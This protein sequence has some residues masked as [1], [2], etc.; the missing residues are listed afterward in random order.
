MGRAISSPPYLLRVGR[1]PPPVR[2]PAV[3]VLTKQPHS[4]FVVFI[5]AARIPALIQFHKGAMRRRLL[6]TAALIPALL[7]V[8]QTFLGA[9]EAPKTPATQP[10]TAPAVEVQADGSILLKA[11]G[12]RIHG[13]RLHLEAKPEPTLVY[14]ID[15]TEYPEWPQAVAKKGTYAVEVTYSCP[16]KAG[17]EF[18]VSGAAGKVVASKIQHTADWQTFTTVN[19]GTLTI[20]ND[21]TTINIRGS[22]KVLHA[23]MNLRSI[24][25]T[26]VAEEPPK[27]KKRKK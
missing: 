12:A 5:N 18:V 17:G 26:P 19:L 14:W 25:L 9:A 20:L 21:N 13:F 23:L 10:S 22:G 8:T 4:P 15:M 24:K 3:R 6:A 7:L 2:A 16:A 1:D 27:E 11:A